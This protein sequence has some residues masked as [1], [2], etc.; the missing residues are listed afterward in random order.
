MKRIWKDDQLLIQ[1]EY[2]HETQWKAS[3]EGGLVPIPVAYELFCKRLVTINEA[4]KILEC[5]KANVYRIIKDKEIHTPML[6]VTKTET[7]ERNIKLM[8]VDIE[9]LQKRIKGD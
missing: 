9:Q 2:F 1:I 4:A 8:H 5:T 7:V 3:V 6:E